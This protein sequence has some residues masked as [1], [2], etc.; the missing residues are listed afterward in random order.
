[1]GPLGLGP[2]LFLAVRQSRP[3]QAFQLTVIEVARLGD[4]LLVALLDDY[5]GCPYR[6]PREV[7]RVGGVESK[8]RAVDVRPMGVIVELEVCVPDPSSVRDRRDMKAGDR[9]GGGRVL[10]RR[11]TWTIRAV[12]L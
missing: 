6:L 4:R 8:T 7:D 1:M 11:H 3:E 5:D 10:T 12:V 9:S 2:G